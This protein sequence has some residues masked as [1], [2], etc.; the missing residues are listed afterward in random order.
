[1]KD[2]FTHETKYGRGNI[3]KMT[4]K[5]VYRR[6]EYYCVY[7]KIKFIASELTIDHLI[8]L[9]LGGQ[10][11]ITNYVTSCKKCNNK[12]GH[13]RLIDFCDSLRLPIEDLPLYG[14]P[15]VDNKNLPYALRLIRRRIFIKYR[16][17]ELKLNNK[18]SQKKI[19]KIYRRE[20]W[21]TPDGKKLESQFPNLPGHVRIMIPEILTIADSKDDFFLLVELA[22]SA[23]T[24]NIIN[25]KLLLTDDIPLQIKKLAKTTKDKNLMKRLN[26][27]FSRFEKLNRKQT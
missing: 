1:M 17:D 18:S 14:D 24:R 21:E 25:N 23:I 16:K 8:P 20:F 7:C 2:R 12:K 9:A 4:R 5:K 27:A 3:P 13:M 19:E 11:E 22:K 10:N 6:D 26:Q 15:V